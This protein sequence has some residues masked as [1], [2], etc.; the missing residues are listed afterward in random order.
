MFL[1]DSARRSA[2]VDRFFAAGTSAA[3]RRGI[4]REYGV[5]W[6]V[7]SADLAGPGLRK[8]TTGPGE[9]VLYRVVG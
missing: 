7:A 4:L 6:V 8:V 5:R 3:E 2:A 1:R 9:Q